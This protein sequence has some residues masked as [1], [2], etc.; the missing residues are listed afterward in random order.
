MGIL[1][2]LIL[3]ITGT[4]LFFIPIVLEK[5]NREKESESVTKKDKKAETKKDEKPS[6]NFFA[7]LWECVFKIIIILLLLL[8]GSSIY[9]FPIVKKDWDSKHVVPV[10]T[11][12]ATQKKT[13][14]KS[15]PSAQQHGTLSWIKPN[16]VA[17]INSN[18]RKS[19]PMP[20]VIHKKDAEVLEFTATINGGKAHFKWNK[21]DAFGTWSEDCSGDG[22]QWRL[23]PDK[24]NPKILVGEESDRSGEFIRLELV[25]S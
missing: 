20:V 3:F 12:A 22:G 17:G 6:K 24:N 18:M 25:L 10:K 23:Y 15:S 7:D 1:I 4:V 11:T 8:L 16:N 21:R 2:G 9:W 14:A 13:S 19:P 5:K